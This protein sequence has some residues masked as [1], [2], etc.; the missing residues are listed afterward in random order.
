MHKYKGVSE[1]QIVAS[2]AEFT[3]QLFHSTYFISK[4]NAFLVKGKFGN[5]YF[6]I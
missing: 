4:N 3:V 2:A 5:S 6:L 1:R